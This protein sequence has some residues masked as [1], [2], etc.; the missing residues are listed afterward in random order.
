MSVNLSLSD[1]QRLMEEKRRL[2]EQYQIDKKEKLTH[3]GVSINEWTNDGNEWIYD[4]YLRSNAIVGIPES[5]VKTGPNTDNELIERNKVLEAD[6][7]SLL[8]QNKDLNKRIEDLEQKIKDLTNENW[9][10]F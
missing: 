1:F 3:G 8:S 7:Q 4:E 5:Y 6:N 9:G 2:Q 10:Q